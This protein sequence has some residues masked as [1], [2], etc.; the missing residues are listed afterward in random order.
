MEMAQF[1][2]LGSSTLGKDANCPLFFQK[3]HGRFD[4]LPIPASAANGKR[5]ESPD[6]LGKKRN[7]EEFLFGH[8]THPSRTGATHEKRVKIAEMVGADDHRSFL[9]NLLG[10]RRTEAVKNKEE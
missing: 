9:G 10:P 3:L 5:S 1:T 7:A 4:C 8:E 2:G 6:Q